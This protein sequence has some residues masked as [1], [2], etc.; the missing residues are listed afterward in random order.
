MYTILGDPKKIREATAARDCKLFVEKN[1]KRPSLRK[2]LNMANEAA[3]QEIFTGWN[4]WISWP[5]K[6]AAGDSGPHW[7]ERSVSSRR[8]S[9]RN[10]ACKK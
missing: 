3:S 6:L 4:T 1:S 8:G 9:M 5:W 2:M 7:K 10:H